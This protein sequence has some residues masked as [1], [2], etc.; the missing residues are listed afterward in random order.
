M[1]LVSFLD[2]LDLPP[3]AAALVAVSAGA[4]L[5]VLV[6][7]VLERVA[8]SLTKRT[9][10]RS[11]DVLIA[12]LRTPVTILLFLIGVRVALE[13][14][15]LPARYATAP[16]RLVLVMTIFV[17]AYGLGASLLALIREYAPSSPRL[18]P[19]AGFLAGLVKAVVLFLALLVSLDSVG[20]SITPLLASLGVGSVAVALAL[21]DTLGNLF[22]GI[23]LLADHPIRVGETIRVEPDIEGRVV[24]IGW[25]T[26]A[27]LEG[28]NNL[29][30][31]PNATLAKAN[32]RN[33]DR[34]DP[35]DSVSLRI[36]VS[37][38]TPAAR[39]LLVVRE[40]VEPLGGTALL[41][42]LDPLGIELTATVP[43]E[44]R[45]ARG[46]VR[47]RAVE[48]VS[49]AFQEAGVKPAAPPPVAPPAAP[50]AR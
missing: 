21:Q 50:T 43:A 38:E 2:R 20:V 15:E 1:T 17:A 22:A 29:A 16:K 8:R 37:H 10:T 32:V 30:I 3:W 45:T 7:V 39:A 35:A 19:I 49:A 44:N 4:L 26:T 47:S 41:T 40:A 6:R 24:E 12:A 11:D 28:N 5:A 27:I 46:E 18:N 36:L 23:A 13:V 48:A 14:A 34:P 25:R 31:I 9:A 42:N 33:F